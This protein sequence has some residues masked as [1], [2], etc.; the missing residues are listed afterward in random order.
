MLNPTMLAMR[1]LAMAT[2]S[3][4]AFDKIW[5]AHL[6]ARLDDGRD[7]VFVDRHV[8]QIAPTPALRTLVREDAPGRSCRSQKRQTLPVA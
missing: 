3:A 5:N 1:G 7:L 6:V 8:L 2:E 4:T